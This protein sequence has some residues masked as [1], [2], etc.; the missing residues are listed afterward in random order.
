MQRRLNH[1]QSSV[2]FQHQ[3]EDYFFQINTRTEPNKY[4]SQFK[5]SND[6]LGQLYILYLDKIKMQWKMNKKI[7]LQPNLRIE[8]TNKVRSKIYRSKA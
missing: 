3:S 6:Q 2:G 7:V 4:V 8:I 1:P 5:R